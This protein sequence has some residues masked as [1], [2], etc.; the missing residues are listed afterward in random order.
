VPHFYFDATV[1]GEALPDPEGI[2]LDTRA[3]ARTEGLRAVAEM[4]KD[5]HLNGNARDIMIAIREGSDPVVT[6][7]LSLK[8]EEAS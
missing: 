6:I 5:Q 3:V 1:N 2:E 8:I 4:V 7:R